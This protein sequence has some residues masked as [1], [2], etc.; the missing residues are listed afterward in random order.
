MNSAVIAPTTRTTL[1]AVSDCSKRGDMRATMNIPAVTMVAAWISAEMGVGPSMESGSQTCRGNWADFPIAPMKSRMHIR[2]ATDQSAPG[3][4]AQRRP[5]ERG[6]QLEHFGV[7][8]SA[9][10]EQHRRHPEQKAEISDPVHEKR[11]QVGA[12]GG[13]ALKPEPD[14]EVGDHADRFPPE[15]ELQE[16]VRHAQHEHCEGEQGDVAEESLVAR[17]VAHVSD[18]VDVHH[19]RNEGHHEHHGRAQRVHEEP[20]LQGQVSDLAP[21]V[22][23]AFVGGSPFEHD[24]SE[25]GARDQS[26]NAHAEDADPVR[27]PTFLWSFRTPRR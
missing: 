24:V 14:E 23:R 25:G 5:L 27:P 7:A 21:V 18:G 10:V 20:Y 12:Y 16:V 2:L 11:L 3:K 17:I 4:D 26:R 8:Q 1:S 22:E 19:E 15:E 6:R 13:L 9:E